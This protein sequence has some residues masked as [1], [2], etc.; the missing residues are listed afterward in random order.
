[1]SVANI[2]IL[3][4]S[5]FEASKEEPLAINIKKAEKKQETTSS[6]PY[7]ENITNSVTGCNVLSNNV[8]IV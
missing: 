3:L 6:K 8:F 1:M 7:Q 4:T 5:F 2:R